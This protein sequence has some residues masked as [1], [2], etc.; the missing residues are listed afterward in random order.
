LKV[1]TWRIEYKKIG[2]IFKLKPLF[3]LH[4]G[5]KGFDQA[6]LK[7]TLE[8]TDDNTLF[9]GGGDTFDSI[10]CTDPRYFKGTDGTESAE[11]ID[12]QVDKGEE[13]LGPYRD[14]IIGLGLGNHEQAIVKK[15]GTNPVKRLCK[16]LGV[17]YLGYSGFVKLLFS[18]NGGRGRTVVV[19]YHHGYGGGSRTE[20][21]A[22][23]KYS[24]QMKYFQ[25]DVGL[26]GHDHKKVTHTIERMGIVGNDL[27]SKP[28][29]VCLCGS[30]QKTYVKGDT[31]YAELKGFPPTSLGGVV[32]EIKPARK[33]VHI[34]ART[35]RG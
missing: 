10:I 34:Y 8:G 32:I 27:V 19:Y 7:R 1:T 15:F 29:T 3:D 2:D 35:E 22:L 14:K 21:G 24:K 16:R 18:Q 5:H 12:E 31:T 17:N 20:G 23:T 4:I 11:I 30:Y 28:I 26:F 6:A 13:L 9:I 33:W 25:S